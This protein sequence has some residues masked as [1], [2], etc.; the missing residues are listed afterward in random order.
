M[1]NIAVQI[2][3]HLV[4]VPNTTKHASTWEYD[5][6]KIIQWLKVTFAAYASIA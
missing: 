2:W 3:Y 6:L 5:L 4:D 1:Q